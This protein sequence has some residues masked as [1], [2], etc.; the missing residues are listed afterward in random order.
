MNI[1]L[2]NN[3]KYY[4]E[5]FWRKNKK[6]NERDSEGKTYPWPHPDPIKW[7]EESQFTRKLFKVQDYLKTRNKYNTEISKVQQIES[8]PVVWDHYNC[9][10][11]DAKN[12]FNGVFTMNNISWRDDLTHYISVHNI[13]PS[14]DFIDIIYQFSP[15]KK[16]KKTIQWESDI[17]S[18]ESMQYLKLEKNQILIMDAL[19]KHGGYT[20]KYFDK[21]NNEVF[22]YSEHAGLLDFID[23]GLD[24]I[25]I[26]GKTSRIDKGDEEIYLPKD[27]P[28]A[29]DYEYIFHT[30]PPTP[31]PGGRAGQGIMYEFPSISDLFHFIDHYNNGTTQGSLV[32]TSEGLYNIRKLELDNKKIKINENSMY[33]EMNNI[34]RHSQ[35]EAIKKYGID[36]SS[37]E[38]Y[39]KIAQDTKYI[40]QINSV[41]NKYKINIDYFPR[42]KDSKGNWIVESIHLPV[43]VIKSVD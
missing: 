42:H 25:I 12:I 13:K 23:T 29:L 33:R 31:K 24:K 1:K 17:Y 6:D 15:I 10:L 19:M 5:S 16:T 36:F 4:Y 32:I 28:Y 39:S 26:S 8:S 40:S 20:K 7:S 21:N 43:F 38:F 3:K 37:Y 35:M 41:L 34:M 30:H 9:I 18:I 14:E 22:R 2:R 11:C 27:M